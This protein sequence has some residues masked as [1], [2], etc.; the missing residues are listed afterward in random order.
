MLWIWSELAGN[1]I[2]I[3]ITTIFASVSVSVFTGVLA[4]FI[5]KYHLSNLNA[6]G[7]GN[8]LKLEFCPSAQVSLA[9]GFFRQPLMMVESCCPRPNQSTWS[10]ST[11]YGWSSSQTAT[12]SSLKLYITRAPRTGSSLDGSYLLNVEP[13]FAITQTKN[14]KVW[15]KG[16]GTT[17]A[18]ISWNQ[19]SLVAIISRTGGWNVI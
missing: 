10:S 12:C 14:I 2:K 1:R 18:W 7:L 5:L 16:N 6:Q 13:A 15:I 11:Q 3:I 9:G 19:S 17:V 4:I 8:T